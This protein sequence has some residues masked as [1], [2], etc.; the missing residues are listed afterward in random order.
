MTQTI[1]ARANLSI[2]AGTCPAKLAKGNSKKIYESY[3]GSYPRK[4]GKL[5]T[6]LKP[7][8]SCVYVLY[9]TI[10]LPI[11]FAVMF[12]PEK[13]MCIFHSGYFFF[14]HYSLFHNPCI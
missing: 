11:F 1:V 12:L 9:V 6:A 3:L 10:E 8:I 2:P 7:R 13:H 14:S 5:E 4:G